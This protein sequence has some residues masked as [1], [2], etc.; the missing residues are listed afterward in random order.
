[1]GASPSRRRVQGGNPDA[2]AGVTVYWNATSACG[3]PLGSVY[4]GNGG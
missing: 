2:A 1:M 4:D 3:A